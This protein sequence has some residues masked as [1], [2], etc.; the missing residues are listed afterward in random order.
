MA[1]TPVSGKTIQVGADGEFQAA[2]NKAS[3]GDEIVLQAGATYTGNFENNWAHA[4][5]GTGILFTVR[6]QDGKAPWSAVQDVTMMNNLVRNSP[7]A[8]VVMGEDHPNQSQ[9]SQRFLIRNNLF[10]RIEGTAFTIT[11][12]ADDIEIDHNT[13]VPNN[14]SSYCMTRA[15]RAR[16]IG[17]GGWE[18]VQ[19]LQADQ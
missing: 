11:S 10:E 14:Y 2:L 13:F 6:N 15:G 1:A 8:S 4:Q 9:Q 17:Q 16:S 18:T 19:A 7:T 3:P 5:A 12:G